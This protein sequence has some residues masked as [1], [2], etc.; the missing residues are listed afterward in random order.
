MIQAP[1][2][3]P[4]DPRRAFGETAKLM[5][6]ATKTENK[7]DLARSTRGRN[8]RLVIVGCGG[9][10]G[11]HLLDALLP[12]PSVR[13]GGWD[14][15]TDKISHHLSNPNVNIRQNPLTSAADLAEF[16]DVI[17]SADAVVNLAAI[18]NPSEYNVNPINVIR[19]NFIEPLKIV[20][21][22]VEQQKWLVHFSTS[23]VYGRTLASYTND[24]SYANPDLYELSEDSTPLIMGP[25]RNQRW[26][27]AAA[28]QLMERYIYGQHREAGLPY[29]I[30]R[31]LNFFGPR[32]DF[33]PGRDGEGVPR[34]LACFMTALLDGQ[35]MQL[36]D[37]GTAR[38]TIISIRDAI[39]AVVL[40]LEKPEGAKN[41]I[42]NIGN[43]R[44]EVTMKE[45]A[46]LMRETYAACTGNPAHL[47]HPIVSVSS[48]EFY[49]EGYEDCDRRMPNVDK[50]KER[51]GWEPMLS[52]KETL[53]ETV[54]YY[55][56]QYRDWPAVPRKA[57]ASPA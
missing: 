29:T 39:R 21:A 32:M 48:R 41:Q 19:S 35:P 33:I 40:M 45:L 3:P 9:F 11:S 1:A 31:P 7:D 15:Q 24:T 52:L 46:E 5:M 51:L 34:V 37:G 53:R 50:A 27:Y 49:G 16:K 54:T 36:V 25:I 26:S 4:Q 56:E 17:R 12:D 28:K 47:E 43:R 30:V 22:C 55:H 23:E 20:D 42:F 57:S 14:P 6:M 10:I 13:I 2:R 38:R 18:C 8:M 44:N